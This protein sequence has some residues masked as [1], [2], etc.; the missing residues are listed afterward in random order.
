MRLSPVRREIEDVKRLD[1]EPRH[2]QDDHGMTCRCKPC[3][4]ERDHLVQRGVRP[5]GA[6]SPWPL[7]AESR[8]AWWDELED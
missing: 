7:P 3:Q 1:V 5:S 4:Q 2:A 6:A 8:F